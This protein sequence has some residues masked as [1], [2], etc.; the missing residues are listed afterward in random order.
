VLSLKGNNGYWRRIW[1]VC[2]LMS[3]LNWNVFI[4]FITL[5]Y[6]ISHVCLAYMLCLL[7]LDHWCIG[8]MGRLDRTGPPPAG[9]ASRTTAWQDAAIFCSAEVPGS[10]AYNCL[11]LGLQVSEYKFEHFSLKTLYCLLLIVHQQFH[12]SCQVKQL[13][14]YWISR[15]PCG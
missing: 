3:P 15:K 5:A 14:R 13:L 12:R 11:L 8:F 7:V 4:H 9:S 1:E 10:S 6:W 2:S